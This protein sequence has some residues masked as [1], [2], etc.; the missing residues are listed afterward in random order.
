VLEIIPRDHPAYPGVIRGEVWVCG[1]VKHLVIRV[2]RDGT[3]ADV[4][5]TGQRAT[6][7]PVPFPDDWEL[8]CEYVV[9]S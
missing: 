3:W 4:R 7:V 1:G 2:A 9:L 5:L 8:T 6:R